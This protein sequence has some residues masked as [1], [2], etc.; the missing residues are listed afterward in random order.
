M[1]IHRSVFGALLKRA[2]QASLILIVITL[3]AG[4]GDS[5]VSED[6][7][8]PRDAQWREDLA[9]LVDRMNEIHPDLY[10][11]VSRPVF[12]QARARLDSEI[13]SLSDDQI[14]VEF[15]RLVALPA[16]QRDGHMALSFF[17]GT[18]FQIVPIQLYRF[19]DGVFV[20][21]ASPA[22]SQVLG[23]KLLGIGEFTLEEVNRLIDPLIPRDN[24]NSL[25]AF[26]NLVYITPEIL[27]VL[28]II[29][30]AEA[31][32]YRFE[33]GPVVLSSVSPSQYG[34]ESIYNLPTPSNPPLYLTRRN[35]NFWLE[36]LQTDG[37][38]Y[39][40]LN[41]VQPT[42]GSEDLDEFGQRVLALMDGGEIE[43]V[44]LDLRQNNG[45]N[46]QLIPGILDFLTDDRIN[47][48]GRLFVF[49]DRNTFSAA[50]NLVAAIGSETSAQFVGVSPGGSGSQYG[51][52]ERVDLPNSRFAAFIPSRHWIFGDSGA[53]PLMHPM[54]VTIEPTGKEFLD[55]AD[56]LLAL[57]TG[58]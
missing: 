29:E 58:G 23:M 41:A 36:H 39:M 20:V 33:S 57:Y 9:H 6:P 50:G 44:I 49:T 35:Q 22:N 34:L 13:P 12:E 25:I 5:A 24:E 27:E 3:I 53:Q 17:E 21:D 37:I 30:D 7:E 26:R 16:T 38:L 56:P 1:H 15:L 46:N 54:D 8:D 32:M 14:F 43:R 2:T 31:P 40:R 45:G 11:T 52:A 51:D 55:G 19:S 48:A 10:H 42:S 4:C 28:G 47:Q 18:G